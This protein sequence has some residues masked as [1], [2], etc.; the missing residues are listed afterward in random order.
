ML[1]LKI[2]CVC[3]I[4]KPIAW[5]HY[6]RLRKGILWTECL[7]PQKLTG[8]TPN[9]QC[10][11]LW[12]WAFGR[13]SGPSYGVSALKG[14]TAEPCSPSL[15]PVAPAKGRSCGHT[16]RRHQLQVKERDLTQNQPCWYPG[17]RFP[18]SRTVR[19]YIS[20]VEAAQ[21]MVFCY[22]KPIWLKKGIS[23]TIYLEKVGNNLWG[24]SSIPRNMKDGTEWLKMWK[25]LFLYIYILVKWF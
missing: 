4:S 7:C 5:S 16:V 2:R 22:D 6:F 10:D 11:G 17:L 18:T 12:R 21:T 15:L 3:V 20:V 8:Q 19:K 24:Y 13:P 14:E 9:P 23:F 1:K 25:K